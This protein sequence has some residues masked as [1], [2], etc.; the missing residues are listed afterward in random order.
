M[1][2]KHDVQR[3]EFVADDAE[4]EPNDHRVEHDSKFKDDEGG[5]L[6]AE[7]LFTGS[8]GGGIVFFDVL[9]KTGPKSDLWKDVLDSYS[10]F[11]IELSSLT[12]ME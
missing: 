1:E 8:G 12:N 5:D 6:L 2:D 9:S 11:L 4:V 10:P 3:A 7:R